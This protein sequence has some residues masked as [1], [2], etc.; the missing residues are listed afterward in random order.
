[1]DNRN[2]DRSVR[3]S[4]TQTNNSQQQQYN[5]QHYGSNNY[6]DGTSVYNLVPTYQ[7]EP[8]ETGNI[9]NISIL[10]SQ[11]NTQWKYS[12]KGFSYIKVD[13]LQPNTIY[14]IKTFTNHKT[15]VLIDLNNSVRH[16]FNILAI[17]G[18]D[19]YTTSTDEL[20]LPKQNNNFDIY[21]CVSGLYEDAVE[22]EFIN[23]NNNYSAFL[24]KVMEFDS[25]DNIIFQ[26]FPL[27]DSTG[28][29]I[30]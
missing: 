25:E 2:I 28:H 18:D 27:I 4:S 23:R 7:S 16:V 1:M 24:Y 5:H 12:S 11:N 13:G 22:G 29:I 6:A 26:H 19:I 3:T 21:L 15:S 14:K 30:S 10:K 17:I 8:V 9:A 20:Y